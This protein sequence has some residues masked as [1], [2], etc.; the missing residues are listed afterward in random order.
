M[1]ASLRFQDTL[2]TVVN[3]LSKL[4]D[5]PHPAWCDDHQSFGDGDPGW[6]QSR[7]VTIGGHTV[8]ITAGG[9][10][11]PDSDFR[12]GD[13]YLSLDEAEQL[14]QTLRAAVKSVRENKS[15]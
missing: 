5:K 11:D 14:G 8:C 9:E 2:S 6:H 15:N 1:T 10:S 12:L 7:E 3:T 4:H 13:D